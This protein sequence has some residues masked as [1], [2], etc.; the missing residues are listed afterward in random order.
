MHRFTFIAVRVQGEG[1][2]FESIAAIFILI[3]RGSLLIS[4]S[5]THHLRLLV[6]D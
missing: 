2:K 3:L 5:I 1:W 4:R 6:F